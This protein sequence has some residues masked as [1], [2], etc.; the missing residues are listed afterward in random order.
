MSRPGHAAPHSP[1]HSTLFSTLDLDSG[2]WIVFRPDESGGVV[3]FHTR[4]WSNSPSPRRDWGLRDCSGDGQPPAAVPVRLCKWI[5]GS[6]ETAKYCCHGPLASVHEVRGTDNI[7]TWNM[8]TA[9]LWGA[10]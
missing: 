3:H 1:L 6:W 10:V 4:A 7:T 8:S 5:L 2:F 9:L